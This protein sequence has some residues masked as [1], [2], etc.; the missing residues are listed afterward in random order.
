MLFR[1]F[2]YFFCI[3]FNTNAFTTTFEYNFTKL[4]P[5]RSWMDNQV[6]A[7]GVRFVLPGTADVNHIDGIGTIY[8]VAHLPM[9]ANVDGSPGNSDLRNAKIQLTIKGTNLELHGGKLVW[10]VV[11]NIPK[12]ETSPYFTYQ[13]SNWAYTEK[14]LDE[15]V[16]Q[17]DT[18]SN[19][20]FTL[21]PS[22]VNW[23]YAGTNTSLKGSWGNRY[24]RYPIGKL[25]NNIDETLHFV[26]IGAK[27]PPQGTIEIS[28][29]KIDTTTAPKLPEYDDLVKLMMDKKWEEAAPK[30]KLLADSGHSGAAFHY[31][32]ILNYGMIGKVDICAAR[33]YYEEAEHDVIEAS[34]ELANQDIKAICNPRNYSSAL[35]RLSRAKSMP[36]ARFYKAM[37]L[38]HHFTEKADIQA[39]IDD[40]KYAA[41]GGY[42]DAMGELGLIY[43][44]SGKKKEALYWLSLAEQKALASDARKKDLFT[45]SL[46]ALNEG[47]TIT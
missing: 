46:K 31:A 44:G 47:K 42:V 14:M 16:L 27:K 24:V 7:K 15:K 43:M 20:S 29:I 4:E 28:N 36:R 32:N 34:V 10:W 23:T 19:I 11:A 6:T 45:A 33:A 39:V 25:L 21:A 9:H 37:I 5:W 26:I 22:P 38:L 3:C 12:S 41:D 18:W 30:L 35:K 40:L 17:N 13:Q 8:L 2:F 1:V